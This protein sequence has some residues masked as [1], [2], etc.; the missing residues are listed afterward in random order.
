MGTATVIKPISD[1]QL[2]LRTIIFS[3]VSFGFFYAYTSWLGIP[4]VLNKSAADVAIFLIGLSMILSGICYFWNVFDTLIKYRKYLGMVGWA[5]AIA[6]LLLSWDA[7]LSLLNVETWQ[8]GAMW[9][10][11][12]GFLA[13]VIF[14]IMALIS[15]KFMA[16]FLGQNWR[17]LLRTGYIA[18]IFVLAHVV[19]LR[20][21]R[22]ISWY[23]G[24]MQTPP[25]SSIIVTVFMLL[26]LVMRVALWL[27]TSRKQI[28]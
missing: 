7:F 1:W 13:T 5:F 8:E 11:L 17:P 26:V 4:N 27:A 23:E 14:T 28:A 16:T 3:F 9:P 6:H 25:S 21:P 19:L 18:V 10:V 24:G 2:Y 12:T 20:L 22:W 15:N